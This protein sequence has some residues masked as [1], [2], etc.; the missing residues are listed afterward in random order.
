MSVCLS[1]C[2][3]TSF[4][5]TY[6]FDTFMTK[7]R[8]LNENDLGRAIV[9]TILKNSFNQKKKEKEICDFYFISI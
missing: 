9:M 4:S 3:S 6:E 7:G 8:T 5:L 1:V 2:L